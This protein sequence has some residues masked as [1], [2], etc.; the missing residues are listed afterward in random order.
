MLNIVYGEMPEAVYNTSLYF[1]N[2]YYDSWL[3]DDFAKEM[4]KSVDKAEVL[5][6]QAVK[7]K[8]LG[9]IPTTR[10]S[11]GLKTLLLIY[12]QPEKVFNAST[13]GDNCAKWLL[14]IADRADK[15]ITVNLRHIMDF[16]RGKFAIRIV[17]NNTIVYDM[18]ELVE[19]AGYYIS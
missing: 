1:D 9:V 7:S 11:G 18:S 6:G 2:T 15:D 10:I 12:N 19:Y 17:N 8:A 5:S 14:R 3:L 13:C 4:I 16:G